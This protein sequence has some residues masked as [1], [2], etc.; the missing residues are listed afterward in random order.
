MAT[1]AQI[2]AQID[3]A[4]G[5]AERPEHFTNFRH[6]CECAEHDEL[7]CSRDLETLSIA[8][9]GNPGWDPPCFTSAQGIAYFFRPLARLAFAPPDPGYGWYA[10]Q[11]LFHL[12][13]GFR[14]NGLYNFFTP[15]QRSSVAALIAHIIET[16]TDLVESCGSAHEFLQCHE[17]W[18]ERKN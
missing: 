5:P 8:D 13:Y 11:L 18:D 15:A 16:R 12:Y 7:L 2:L 6:Y 3:A 10:D 17:L 9:V 1:D 14:D 4:F